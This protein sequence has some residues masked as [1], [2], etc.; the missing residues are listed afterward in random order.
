MCQK[1]GEA[2]HASNRWAA[3]R[4]LDRPP[5]ADRPG[6]ASSGAQACNL[7][8]V[9]RIRRGDSSAVALLDALLELCW[10]S[11]VPGVW[12]GWALPLF[13]N[14]RPPAG[15]RP[16]APF[17]RLA[18]PPLPVPFLILFTLLTLA[19][20]T[21]P[22]PRKR[23]AREESVKEISSRS[24]SKTCSFL[25]RPCRLFNL[26]PPSYRRFPVASVLCPPPPSFSR[27]V[28]WSCPPW[29]RPRP[30]LSPR[31]PALAHRFT[32]QSLRKRASSFRRA[33][34]F[35]FP[36]RPVLPGGFPSDRTRLK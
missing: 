6:A 26:P 3:L 4:H 23:G 2:P 24:F 19:R 9:E 13:E 29:F 36:C 31:P 7:Q 5:G 12:S 10:G 32:F 16:T 28:F 8:P 17:L 33:L 35:R 21:H 20:R 15:D 11:R 18:R 34:T 25:L 27:S 30:P 1:A 22:S 14:C